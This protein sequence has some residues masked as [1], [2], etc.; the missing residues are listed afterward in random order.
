MHTYI[1]IRTHHLQKHRIAFQCLSSLARYG[2]ELKIKSTST[3]KER[4][5][6]RPLPM[7]QC[8]YVSPR[9]LSQPKH[10]M[11]FASGYPMHSPLDSSSF[12]LSRSSCSYT[13]WRLTPNQFEFW[14]F[15]RRCTVA[16][17]QG[18]KLRYLLLYGDM[19]CMH[20]ARYKLT[21]HGHTLVCVVPPTL[22]RSNL[23]YA[24]NYAKTA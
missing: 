1:H 12:S 20:N 19:N 16:N 18:T 14:F 3:Q 8:V 5:R 17:L 23:Y 4:Q 21:H 11:S 9:Q 6:E 7:Y 10:T 24:K 22:G 15:F 13:H 2:Q